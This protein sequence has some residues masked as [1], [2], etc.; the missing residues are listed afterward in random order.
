MYNAG[1]GYK[2]LIQAESR[3]G[4]FLDNV[5]AAV[6]LNESEQI[7]LQ[8]RDQKEGIRSAGKWSLPGGFRKLSETSIQAVKREVFEETNLVLTN[9][10]YF[11]NLID[12]FE[13]SRYV[14]ID[15]YFEKIYFPYK[16]EVNEGQDLKFFNLSDVVYLNT[17]KHIELICL[18]AF[19][20]LK[21]E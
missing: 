6:I 10:F 17:N 2:R 20:L 16:L 7:L 13:G 4:V 21:T 9:P 3:N 11:A 15:F 12:I 18:Y 14:S 1:N 19:E 5:A 8:L